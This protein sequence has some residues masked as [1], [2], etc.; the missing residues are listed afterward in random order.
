MIFAQTGLITGG[1]TLGEPL[2]SHVVFGQQWMASAYRGEQSASE[3]RTDGWIYDALTASEIRFALPDE[4]LNPNSDDLLNQARRQSIRFL[5]QGQSPSATRDRIERSLRISP[6]E[7]DAIFQ[8]LAF[9]MIRNQPVQFALSSLR[10]SAL[11][12]LG[13]VEHL[14]ISWDA[15]RNQAGRSME[16]NWYEVPAD[17]RPGSARYTDAACRVRLN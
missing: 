9:E 5:A 11:V 17:S 4:R 10:G 1:A 8:D 15:R 6:A 7:I 14:G 2:L 16:D 3:Y 12:M 13:R